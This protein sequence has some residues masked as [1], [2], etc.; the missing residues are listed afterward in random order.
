M[1]FLR[2]FAV[3]AGFAFG[4]IG[5]IS[6]GNIIWFIWET[7]NIPEPEHGRLGIDLVTAFRNVPYHWLIV[8]EGFVAGF[9]WQFRRKA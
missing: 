9:V 7:R 4:S 8:L 2:S 1:R 3:G 5:A 6:V